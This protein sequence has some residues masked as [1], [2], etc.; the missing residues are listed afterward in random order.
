VTGRSRLA[1]AALVVLAVA[2]GF[3]LVA[4]AASRC[5]AELPGQ[6]CPGAGTNQAVVIALAALA[7]GWAG[8]A[9][10]Y[11]ADVALRRGIVYRGAW[12]RAARRGLLVA[13][14]VAVLGGLRLG[15]ALSPAG[16]LF[17]VVLAVALE[18]FAVRWLDRP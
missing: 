4:F 13:A 15:G 18:W 1:V 16:G 14:L 6:P 2:T 17:L 3:G 5:P 11:L 7:V 9:F 8:T 12:L 10:A